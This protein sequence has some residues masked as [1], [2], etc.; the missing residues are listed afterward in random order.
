MLGEYSNELAGYLISYL[1][2]T[3]LESP[4]FS[5]SDSLP[6]VQ[7]VF[8]RFVNPLAG[9]SGVATDFVHYVSDRVINYALSRAGRQSSS[10]S[11][12]MVGAAAVAVGIFLYYNK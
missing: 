12:M 1:T 2:F 9:V 10:S 8:K 7:D 3:S 6:T 5:I 11:T 4:A